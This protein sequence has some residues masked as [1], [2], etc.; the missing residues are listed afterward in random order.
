MGAVRY[1]H[2]L[3]TDEVRT[4]GLKGHCNE[5]E[6]GVGVIGQVIVHLGSRL[7]QAKSGNMGVNV[8]AGCR[9]FHRVDPK[10]HITPNHVARHPVHFDRFY[11]FKLDR[12]A[13]NMSMA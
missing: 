11:H 3:H 13:T 10:K 12:K 4:Y 8:G 6:L 5:E 7:D 9:T 2:L 1:G